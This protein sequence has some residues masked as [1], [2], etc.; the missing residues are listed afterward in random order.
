MLLVEDDHE[1]AALV[2]EMLRELG[3]GV[4]RAATAEAALGALANNRDIGL[5]FSDVMMPGGMNGVELAQEI[6][7]RRPSLPI[8][9]TSGYSEAA[10]HDAR[11]AG[12]S[13]LPKPYRLEQLD[14][15]LSAASAA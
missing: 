11:A 15:A 9:L 10:A 6:R 4:T 14:D 3:W 2:T 8:V 13:L 12:I 5:V 1:V 7:R